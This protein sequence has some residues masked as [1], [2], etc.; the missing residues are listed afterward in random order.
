VDV[1]YNQK[2][3]FNSTMVRLKAGDSDTN[4]TTIFRF[5]STMVRL[6]VHSSRGAA[7]YKGGFNSTMVRLKVSV[8]VLVV[9]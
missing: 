5:N 7:L 9:V 3:G 1:E 2:S 8:D 4:K 6:K